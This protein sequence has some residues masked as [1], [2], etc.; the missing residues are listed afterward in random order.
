MARKA[1]GEAQEI[2]V[3]MQ[4][5]SELLNYINPNTTNLDNGYELW[6][7]TQNN[8]STAWRHDG[9]MLKTLSKTVDN[10]FVVP[11]YSLFD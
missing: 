2:F 11:I 3:N 5:I 4:K 9:M 7:S 10:N 8:N 1:A 6:T